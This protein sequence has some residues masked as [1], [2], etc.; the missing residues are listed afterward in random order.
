[1]E[2]LATTAAVETAKILLTIAEK[3][4]KMYPVTK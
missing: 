4:E 2:T 1:M 3:R